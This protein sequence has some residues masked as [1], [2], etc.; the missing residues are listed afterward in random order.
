[1]SFLQWQMVFKQQMLVWVFLD[2][3][4][5]HSNNNLHRQLEL[6]VNVVEEPIEITIWWRCPMTSKVCTDKTKQPKVNSKLQTW[7][8]A[9]EV[10]LQAMVE[11]YL[12]G[13]DYQQVILV[14]SKTTTSS[15]TVFNSHKAKLNL[16]CINIALR[17]YRRNKERIIMCNNNTPTR[18]LSKKQ[19]IPLSNNR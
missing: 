6:M 12:Q 17:N 4:I 16:I 14:V 8:V 1:M 7:K 2:L 5:C 3:W 18:I 15:K 10:N 9:S 13:H 19:L 11:A